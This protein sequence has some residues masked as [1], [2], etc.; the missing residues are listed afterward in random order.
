M[1]EKGVECFFDNRKLATTVNILFLCVLPSQ[2]QS[3][4]DEI[5]ADLPRKCIIYSLVRTI[6]SAR[7]KNLINPDIDLC[8]FKPHYHYNPNQSQ[9]FSK[10]NFSLDILTSLNNVDMINLTNPLNKA[11][12]K[13][14]TFGF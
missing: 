9:I 13:N 10:W 3:V 11:D 6:P 1:K 7:L 4:I 14:L 12:G 5:K 8:I 2:L